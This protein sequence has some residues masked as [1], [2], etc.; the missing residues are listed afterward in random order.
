MLM[1]IQKSMKHFYKQIKI[2]KILLNDFNQKQKKKNV[3][4]GF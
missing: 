3:V 1:L 4:K 2:K